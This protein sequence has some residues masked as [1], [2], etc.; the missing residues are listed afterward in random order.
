MKFS[1]SLKL[2]IT[3]YHVLKPKLENINILI[4]LN[5]NEKMILNLKERYIKFM[6]IQDITAIEIKEKDEIY[7]YIQFLNYDLNYYQCGY[8]IYK[9]KF[10]FSIEHPLGKDAA[11]ASGSIIDIYN[12]FEF[13]HDISTDNGS[14]GCPIILL[15]DLNDL[16]MVIGIHKNSD[17]KLK[18]NGGTF[19]GELINELNHKNINN[20][21][22]LIKI[23]RIIL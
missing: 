19:I 15:N 1:D 5:N 3:N 8:N 21:N 2:L 9:N 17:K 16:V 10:V 6:E 13:D 7:K 12:N 11:C 14:S 23:K 22:E 18:I 20:K 4:E